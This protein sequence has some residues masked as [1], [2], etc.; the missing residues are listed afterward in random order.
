M[1]SL[2]NWKLFIDGKHLLMES[3]YNW[4]VYINEKYI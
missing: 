2:Y 1:E 4:K 3:I